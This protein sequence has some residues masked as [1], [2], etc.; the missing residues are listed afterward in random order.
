I[1]WVA[2]NSPRCWA[3][4]SSD[5]APVAVALRAQLKLVSSSGERRVT[6]GEYFNDDGIEYLTRKPDEILAEIELPALDGWR[7]T[8]RKLRRRGSFDFP[9]LGVAAAVKLSDGLV[10]DARLVLGAVGSSPVDQSALAA[11]L[12]GTR[13]TDDAIQQVA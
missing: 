11:P 6:A 3:V 7:M 9:I 1:C 2:P 13:P 10:E 4:S 5:T 12:I 8:Y